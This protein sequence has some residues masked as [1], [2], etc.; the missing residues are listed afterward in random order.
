VIQRR[1]C[2][3]LRDSARSTAMQTA[4]RCSD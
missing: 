1:R 2:N 4:R 3:C